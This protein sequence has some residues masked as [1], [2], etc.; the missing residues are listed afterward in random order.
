MP[1]ELVWENADEWFHDLPYVTVAGHICLWMDKKSQT[2]RMRNHTLN[3][4]RGVALGSMTVSHARIRQTT[5]C[6]PM[7][8]KAFCIV[9]M[10]VEDVEIVLVKHGQEV[11]DGLNREQLPARVQHETSVEIEIGAHIV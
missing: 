11:E 3:I 4:L 5:I 1:L 7:Y 6:R 8:R 9:D 10:P 2:L